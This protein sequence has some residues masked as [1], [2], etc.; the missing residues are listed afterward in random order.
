MGEGGLGGGVGQ[1]RTKRGQGTKRWGNRESVQ[2][3]L[4]ASA[5]AEAI[6]LLSLSLSLL[7]QLRPTE[8]ILAVLTGRRAQL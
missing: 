2:G 6:L 7:L 5:G 8:G 1:W 4:A 3:P